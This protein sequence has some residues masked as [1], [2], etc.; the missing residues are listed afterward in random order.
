MFGAIFKAVAPSLIGAAGGIAGGLI[1]N[2]SSAKEAS[3]NRK[4]QQQMS[5]TAHQREANDLQAAGMNR[6]L[7]ASK[8]G[9]GASTPSGATATQ[10]DPITPGL[11]SAVS[12]MRGMVDAFKTQAETTKLLAETESE[13]LRP[14]VLSSLNELQTS[15]KGLNLAQAQKAVSEDFYYQAQ[16][17]R[18][19]AEKALT[20]S[21]KLSEDVRRK[22]LGQDLTVAIAE[23]KRARTEGNIDDS[24]YG[25]VMRYIDRLKNAVSPWSPNSRPGPWKRN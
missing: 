19:I 24:T 20:E 6:I 10:S 21:Q 13:K 7:T 22:I 4:F 8:G 5:D 1:G 18:S 25:K 2:A 9:S 12:L 17:E 23:A 3:K 11:N 15:A 16:T 14:G